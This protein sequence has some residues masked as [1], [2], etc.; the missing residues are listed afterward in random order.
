MRRNL[1]DNEVE[2]YLSLLEE[3]HEAHPMPSMVDRI[4]WKPKHS[5]GFS[6]KRL[7]LWDEAVYHSGI[8]A[9]MHKEVL[10]TKVPLKVKAFLWLLYLRKVLTRCHIAS[11]ALDV[12]KSCVL[13]RMEEFVEHLF[14]LCPFTK[15]IWRRMGSSIGIDISFSTLEEMWLARKR[16]KTPRDRNHFALEYGTGSGVGHLALSEPFCFPRKLPLC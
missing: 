10:G 14:I 4:V 11:W 1:N 9:H 8:K 16:M 5:E 7:L 3:H 13:C 12:D 2:G 6:I 15:E